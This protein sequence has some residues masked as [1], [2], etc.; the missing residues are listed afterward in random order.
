MAADNKLLGQ[1]DLLGIPPAP[2]GVPQV[3]V[4]FDIDA[5]GIVNVSAKDK[6]TNKEQKITIQ[7]NGG[8]TEAEIQQMVKDAEANAAEDKKRREAVEAKNQAEGLVHATE[9]QL[10]E[11]G[12][13]ISPQLKSDIEAAIADLKGAL[14]KDDAGAIKAKS[15]ALAGIA[16][17]MGEEIYA[18]GQAAEG[19]A[20]ATGAA[21]SSGGDD[22]VDADF[23]EVNDDKKSA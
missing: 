14:E 15:Q 8:L 5:N 9:K 22:V 7:S 23:E 6:A 4:T 3:E 18:K 11:H 10:A 12:A 1:F 16:M 19:G 2:R 13:A 21:R 20:D 17:K